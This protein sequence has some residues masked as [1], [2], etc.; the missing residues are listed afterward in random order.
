MSEFYG[1]PSRD[2]ALLRFLHAGATVLGCFLSQIA[3]VNESSSTRSHVEAE[4]SSRVLLELFAF[5]ESLF[6]SIHRLRTQRRTS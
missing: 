6:V 5:P 2:A 4:Y 1:A 3:F